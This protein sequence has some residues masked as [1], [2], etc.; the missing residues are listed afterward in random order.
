[1]NGSFIGHAITKPYHGNH[2]RL[3]DKNRHIRT[4]LKGILTC[5]LIS[6]VQCQSFK[7]RKTLSSYLIN[8][9]HLCNW[10]LERFLWLIYGSCHSSHNVYIL[11]QTRIQSVFFLLFRRWLEK[12]QRFNYSVQNEGFRLMNR[13]QSETN[14]MSVVRTCNYTLQK[15]KTIPSG[16]AQTYRYD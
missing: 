12:P 13:N 5:S 16:W 6:L 2:Q 8:I 4:V 9:S 11:E 3:I 15:R 7:M 10:H 14:I 1:M